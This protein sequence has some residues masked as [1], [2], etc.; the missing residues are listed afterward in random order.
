M[1]DPKRRT[2]L[3]PEV[4]RDQLLD[5]AA[6]VIADEG[7]QAM[8]MERVAVRGG[9]S[10]ALVYRYFG[11]RSALLVE[12]YERESDT[13]PLANRIRG[14]RTFEDRL[15]AITAPYFDAV[16]RSGLL[17]HRLVG[18]KSIE[19]DVESFRRQTRASVLRFWVTQLRTEGLDREQAT[20]FATMFQ[21]AVEAAGGLVARREVGREVAEEQF[22]ESA[23]AALEAAKRSAR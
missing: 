20:A 5:A 19:E 1:P 17:F 18:E 2:R 11:T 21:A 3:S 6:T 9:V 14:A 10:K 4:R 13:Q 8:T 15:R 23:L 22:Y 12:L 7:T 16:E